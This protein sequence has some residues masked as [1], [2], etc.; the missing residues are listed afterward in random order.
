MSEG[1][2]AAGIDLSLMGL[3]RAAGVALVLFVTGTF[4]DL[5]AH[6]VLG[7]LLGPEDYGDFAVA[8]GAASI[9]ASVAALGVSVT[10]PKFFPSYVA[11]G[12]YGLAAGFVRANFLAAISVALLASAIGAFYYD[13][14]KRVT[15]GHP[16]AIVWMIVPFMVFNAYF[17]NFLVAVEAELR[18]LAL[19]EVLQPLIMLGLVYLLILAERRVSDDISVVALGATLLLVLPFH[20]ILAKLHLPEQVHRA[21]PEYDVARWVKVA[22][23][24][25]LA[26]IAEHI[27]YQASLQM[28]E[29]F[30]DSEASVGQYAAAIKISDLVCLVD[31]STYLVVAPRLGRLLQEGDKEA[32]QAFSRRLAGTLLF[33]GAGVA[34]LVIAFHRPLMR[35]YGDGFEGAAAPL[36]ILAAGN[37]LSGTLGFAWSLLSLGDHEREPLPAIALGVV[38]LV[39]ALYFVIPHWHLA[40]AAAC[41]VLISLGFYGW[42]TWRVRQ[43]TGIA[44]LRF[45]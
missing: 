14:I 20:L 13:D 21:K 18:I 5:G 44:L 6:V 10:L 45:W 39:A 35:L 28:V 2:A 32:L 37:V 12:R 23:P 1:K 15:L 43:I 17:F 27:Y 16:V 11:A 26:G 25:A 24:I 34:A 40:G 19:R 41:E 36:L 31:F 42:M 4:V 8:I 38:L 33:G 3:L 7:R 30:D 29:L 9:C 22:L